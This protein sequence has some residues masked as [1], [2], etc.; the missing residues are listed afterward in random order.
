MRDEARPLHGEHHVRA[1]LLRPA[2]EDLGPLL[3]V[4]GAV[5]FN[6][7]EGV[8]SVVQLVF[9]LQPLGIEHTAPFGIGPAGDADADDAA[10]HGPGSGCWQCHVMPP[11]VADPAAA[12]QACRRRRRR[13][14]PVVSLPTPAAHAVD[15]SWRTGR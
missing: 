1:Y 11:T 6:R 12:C 9:P 10:G 3:S 7:G 4:E 2:R 8:R 15:G 14:E 5:D 13:T